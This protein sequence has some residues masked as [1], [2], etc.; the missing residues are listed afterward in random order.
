M[1]SMLFDYPQIYI[2]EKWRSKIFKCNFHVQLGFHVFYSVITMFSKSQNLP[3]STFFYQA[4]K[5]RF[6]FLQSQEKVISCLEQECEILLRDHIEHR[7]KISINYLLII[8]IIEASSLC[9]S[10][11]LWTLW[12]GT[13][14]EN[15][16]WIVPN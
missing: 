1:L 10:D 5:E 11:I 4:G 2:S 16:N 7:A 15:E 13:G 14:N 9:T 8:L 3:S 6:L 12:E